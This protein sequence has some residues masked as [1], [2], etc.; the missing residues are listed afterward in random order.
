MRTIILKYKSFIFVLFSLLC[1]TGFLITAGEET[2]TPQ[3]QKSPLNPNSQQ[4][5]EESLRAEIAL[6]SRMLAAQK[7][8]TQLAEKAFTE[9][10]LTIQ[11]IRGTM[12]RDQQYIEKLGDENLALKIKNTRLHTAK[13]AFKLHLQGLCSRMS[14]ESVLV[15]DTK[16]VIAKYHMDDD[17]G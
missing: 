9:R 16:A 17:M 7:Q 1:T 4:T 14:Q 3:V 12:E 6:L 11:K 5:I 13:Y 2:P 10:E 8:A 15:K